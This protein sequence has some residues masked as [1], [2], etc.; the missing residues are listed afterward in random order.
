MNDLQVSCLGPPS[1]TRLG[2]QRKDYLE[3]E[4]SGGG[5]ETGGIG[6]FSAAACAVTTPSTPSSSPKR[7]LRIRTI[8]QR[9]NA[10]WRGDYGFGC[11]DCRQELGWRPCEPYSS[12][13]WG[14]RHPIAA[15]IPLATVLLCGAQSSVHISS[16]IRQNAK[17]LSW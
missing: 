17:N 7:C 5:M 11:W 14:F 1:A 16:M 2:C 12:C 15:S 8:P 6:L 4:L 3:I 9:S 13:G 10:A